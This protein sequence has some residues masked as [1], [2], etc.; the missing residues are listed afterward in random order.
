MAGIADTGTN[1]RVATS[2]GFRV[3][4]LVFGDL[5]MRVVLAADDKAIE[6]PRCSSSMASTSAPVFG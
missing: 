4:A 5:S 6:V 3:G 1:A 2:V